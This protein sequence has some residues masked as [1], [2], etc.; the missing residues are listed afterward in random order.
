[1]G[2][3]LA[4]NGI[5][6]SLLHRVTQNLRGINSLCFALNSLAP[7]FL[8]LDLLLIITTSL[9]FNDVISHG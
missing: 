7:P 4:E 2:L 9:T 8:F 5:P 1:M 3:P 6:Y